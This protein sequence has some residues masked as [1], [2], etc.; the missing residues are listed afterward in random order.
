MSTRIFLLSRERF[1]SSLTGLVPRPA[2]AW[3]NQLKAHLEKN[4]NQDLPEHII[5]DAMQG[6]GLI[7]REFLG[8]EGGKWHLHPPYRCR[9]YYDKLPDIIH[10][11][12]NDDMP[13]GQL[14]DHDLNESLV[15]WSEARIALR[16]NRWWRRLFK[17]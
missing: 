7:R 15:D 1:S 5:S 2:P 6:K 11:C 9:D 14:G 12:E 17:V 13:E 16:K 3:R 10:R 8:N 4:P